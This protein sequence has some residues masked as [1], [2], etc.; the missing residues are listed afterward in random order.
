MSEA[1]NILQISELS[2]TAPNASVPEL[3]R[4]SLTLE[5]G[6]SVVLLGQAG[7]GKEALIRILGGFA[8]KSDVISG[9]LRF[10]DGEAQPAARRARTPIR[11]AY[12]PS[13]MTRPFAP[14]A[15]VLAQLSRILARKQNAPIASAREEL[16]LALGRLEGAP[17]L[18]ELDRKPGA[19]D[20]VT[21]GLGLLA[22]VSAQT[23]D[24][25]LADHT[26][27]DLGP[28]AVRMLLEMLA[29]EQK[30]L[31]FALLYATGGLQPA[32]RLGGRVVVIRD[33]RV[34]EEGDAARLMSGHAHSY[35]RTLFK[36]LPRLDT[37]RA[38]VG[39]AARGQPLLQVH[40]LDF[41]PPTAGP[42]R[43]G[44]TFELRWGASLALI[45][46]EGSGRRALAR[47]VLGLERAPRG[48]VVF[49]AVDLN[50]LSQTMSARL[51]RRVAFI[52][53][54]DDAL[55]PRMTLWD[56]VDEP[57]RAH[58][59]LSRDLVAGHRDA[60]LTRVGLA[61]HDGKRAV[62]TLSAFDK[63]RLQVARA[64]VGAPLLVVADEPL[65]GLDAFAQTIMREVLTD[66]R[67]HQGPAFLVITSD[68]TV[69]QALADDAFVFRDGKVVERGPIVDIL[70]A[71]KDGATRALIEAVTLP[72]LSPSLSP[73]P[74]SV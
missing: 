60:A 42:S 44:L 48:R 15:N 63:R 49:D 45:G 66:F 17:E 36:A 31:G 34:V 18:S 9:T 47:A 29:A 12:L 72:G 26:L 54:A 21:L 51:R 13:P 46:E 32:I 35:T 67:A 33:G 69:A 68:F 74:A 55:D 52:T 30:R 62:S 2:V 38:P 6:Q 25:V 57:L 28:G 50:I 27:A 65:R 41:H 11:I 71:P 4:F 14:H 70:R 1:R 64:I 59:S 10:G 16:R 39:R 73:S 20:P 56:T 23:P 40:G 8:Q 3:D 24:L 43:E 58:L 22:C 61:S 5:A 53:G 37:D 19:I 7:S